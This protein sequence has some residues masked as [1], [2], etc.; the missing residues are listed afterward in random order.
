MIEIKCK[1]CSGIFKDYPGNKRKFCSRKCYYKYQEK[2]P[3]NSVFKKGHNKGFKKGYIPWN[4]GRVNWGELINCGYCKK[5]FRI[6]KDR[7]KEKRKFSFCCSYKC[8][9]KLRDK[10]LSTINE[11]LRRSKRFEEWRNFIFERDNY[12]CQECN[13]QSGELNAHHIFEFARYL[14]Y[15]F[16]TTFGITLCKK[17][18]YKIHGIKNF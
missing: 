12:I 5:E 6:S 17:C 8:A 11:R 16:N 13:Q 14:E 7:L 4:K 1:Q 18:H 2:Y 10:G 15:R 3:H 9:G